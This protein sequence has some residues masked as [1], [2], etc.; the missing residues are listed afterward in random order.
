M[1]D[2]ST[3]FVSN[4]SRRDFFKQLVLAGS[5]L[6]LSPLLFQSC[7]T[8]D[9]GRPPF[10]VWED[11]IKMLEQ[12]PDHLVGRRKVLVASKN[13]K[14]MTEFVRDSF[15]ILPSKRDFYKY[16]ATETQY[17][18]EMALRCGLAT[19]RE[20][21]EILKNMLVEAG[22]EAKVVWETTTI[23]LDKVKDITFRQYIPEFDP[24]ISNRKMRKWHKA[25]GVTETNRSFETIPDFQQKTEALANDLLGQ[26][27]E[28][29]IREK[30]TEQ[31]FD[32][33]GIPSVVFYENEE[34]KY[35]HIFDPEVPF[36][37]LHPTNENKEIKDA[38]EFKE[39]KEQD[40]TATL[41][42]RNVMDKWNETTL[43][44]GTWKLSELLGNQ[45]QVQFLNN[46]TFGDQ[47]T[48]SVSQISNFTPCLALQDIH[49]DVS[50]VEKRS[51]LG[52]PITLEGEKVLERYT[53]IVQ[54]E[55]EL[56]VALNNI[57]SLE[58]KVYPQAFPKVRLE[59]EP[60][61]AEGNIVGGLSIGNFELVDNGQPIVGWMK[62]NSIS[63]KIL[64]MYDTSGS[65]PKAYRGDGIKEFL[66]Q[67]E[68]MIREA[69]PSAQ[70]FLQETDSTLY[71]SLLNGKQFDADLILYATDG[72]N[73][74]EYDTSYESIYN[75]GPPAILL[76]VYNKEIHYKRLRENIDFTEIAADDQETTIAEIKKYVDQLSFPTYVLTY[77]SFE[78]DKDHK[79]IVKIK[80]TEHQIELPYNFPMND[81]LLGNRM[82]GLYLTIK[83]KGMGTIK[84]VLAGYKP[85]LDRNGAHIKPNRQMI[86]EVHETLLGGLVM[87]FEREA[88]TLS[89]QLTE[90][91][92]TLLSNRE[93][94][95][96]YQDN[97]IPKALEELGK[98]TL[99]YPQ[100]LLSM[101][102][103]LQDQATEK[104]ITYPKGFRTCI[105][106]AIP[107][108]YNKKTRI[109][110]DYLPT[111]EYLSVTRSGEGG[112]RE[113]L[114]KTAQLAILE[115]HMFDDSAYSHLKGKPLLLNM[116]SGSD[117]QF[118]KK[119]YKE[120]FLHYYSILLGRSELKFVDTTLQTKSI[121]KIDRTNGELYGILPDET[122]GGGSTTEEQLKALQVVVQEYSKLVARMNLGMTMTGI[123]TMP[124]GIVATYSITLV[125]LYAL[126]S[127]ALIIMDAGGMDEKINEALGALACDVY[128]EILYSSM[129]RIGTAISTLENIN[130]ASPGNSTIEKLIAGFS[131]SCS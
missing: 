8:E 20:K 40:I 1:K 56:T 68:G 42:C 94:F 104:A 2:H 62:Q 33:K 86:H 77:N 122:G 23:S 61:D 102:Q 51:F 113:T 28:E 129:G 80:G 22:F 108:Y 89:L 72:E 3:P 50:Y 111:S 11:M 79:L 117:E 29:Y 19:P 15:Q 103:P 63:P 110:F 112:F 34:E 18:T 45:L 81:N 14:A 13:P 107:G 105:I 12:S 92:Q 130:A 90:Y 131:V 41:S 54:S 25:L 57:R 82:I 38:R 74:D 128:K 52:E 109:S 32:E 99:S 9:L 118:V 97:N 119:A 67:T 85:H 69:Y 126:A 114:K 71:T 124:I 75:A 37:Q 84:R 91:L 73:S 6:Y 10:G 123:G 125:K 49:K 39:P 65:M 5:G 64:L 116:D 24:P 96:A 21:A 30:P 53:P 60:K 120:N 76:N 59:L 58:G 115:G 98:G 66:T 106:K 55:E 46:M 87:S 36:G 48:K 95:E 47:A 127:Q 70:V 78:E 31:G 16:I 121:W 4:A 101:M 88:P 27:K 93:W 7:N 26:I 43:V 17:G 100:I 44:S 83:G 35:A